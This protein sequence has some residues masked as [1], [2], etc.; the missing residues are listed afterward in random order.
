M[1]GW[2]FL[3]LLANFLLYSYVHQRII[4]LTGDEPSWD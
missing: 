1:R 2:F 3:L 4:L